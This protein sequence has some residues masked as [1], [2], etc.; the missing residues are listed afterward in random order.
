MQKSESLVIIGAGYIGLEVAATAIKY[1]L[2]VTVIEKE[3]RVMNRV[4]SK[5]VSRFFSI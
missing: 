1:G 3:E 2:T 4:V 5:D